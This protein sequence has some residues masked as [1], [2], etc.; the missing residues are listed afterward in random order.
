MAEQGFGGGGW[1]LAGAGDVMAR[2]A[3]EFMVL[4]WVPDVV[5]GEFANVGVILREAR[6]GGRM[7]VR[8]AR[9]SSRVR[10]VDPTVD[11]GLMEEIAEELAQRLPAVMQDDETRPLLDVLLSSFSNGLQ[12]TEPRACLAES[13]DAEM[14]RLL[15]MYVEPAVRVREARGE[16]T[17]RAALV[18]GMRREFEQVGVWALLRKGIA[19]AEY[20]GAGDR[21]RIDCGYV[22]EEARRARMFQAVSLAGE[23]DGA[24]VLAFSAARLREGVRR[25]DGAELE[26]M[27]VVEPESAASSV[28]GYRFAVSAME[29]AAIRVVTTAEM[30]GVAEMARRELR[31]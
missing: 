24:K 1:H 6:P 9:S 17:G 29:G 26:L 27:A 13:L 14:D 16:A 21:L 7:L 12:V 11:T 28:E 3:C 30:A 20:T 8:F 10:A 23:V 4:R 19:A 5:R 15:T 2:V 31:V 18:R 22:V 25:V